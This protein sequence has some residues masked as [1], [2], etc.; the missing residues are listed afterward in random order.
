MKLRT[1]IAALM[2][3]VFSGTFA[4]A[5]EEQFLR[6]VNGQI[7]I[8]ADGTVKDV[9]IDN[10]GSSEQSLKTFVIEKI[11]TWE[12]YPVQVDGTPREATAPIYLNLIATVDANDELRAITLTKPRI[13]KSAIEI[14][15]D[16]RYDNKAKKHPRFNYPLVPLHDGV[17]ALV[18]LLLDFKPDGTVRNAAIYEMVLVNTGKRPVKPYARAFEDEAL[19]AIR[20]LRRAPQEMAENGCSSGCIGTY[21]VEFKLNYDKAWNGYVLV[22]GKPVP[23]NTLSTPSDIE[24][25]QL[26]RLKQDPTG[27]P[28]ETGG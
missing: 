18:T 28:L 11:K 14:E 17:G 26:V 20:M 19:D 7:T 23:W 22:P 4:Q 27:Q 12:F 10:I 21:F 25:S 5:R 1:G 13:G 9:A 16:A 2:L 6:S 24:Q 15:I 8:A 3:F